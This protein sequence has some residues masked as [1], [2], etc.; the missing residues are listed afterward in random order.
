M[1]DPAKKKHTF[2]PRMAQTKSQTQ[3]PQHF[4]YVARCR[5]FKR[6][7][8][9]HL[10]ALKTVCALNGQGI[11]PQGKNQGRNCGLIKT[12]LTPQHLDLYGSF[13]FLRSLHSLQ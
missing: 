4:I 12:S 8:I 6:Q 13:L 10:L 9:I 1:M 3:K 11:M 5:Q 7:I 2:F